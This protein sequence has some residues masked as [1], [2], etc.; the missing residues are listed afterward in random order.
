[1][2]NLNVDVDWKQTNSP[3]VEPIYKFYAKTTLTEKANRIFNGAVFFVVGAQIGLSLAKYIPTLK[4]LSS[5][6]VQIP[7]LTM[8]MNLPPQI[9]LLIPLLLVARKI[10]AIAINIA[11]YPATILPHVNDDHC[12]NNL[13]KDRLETA[14][15]CTENNFRFNAVT[16]SKS[17]VN[18]D[19]FIFGKRTN[20]DNKNWV[21][22]AGGNAWIGEK[23]I[24]ALL[25]QPL[26]ENCN[27]LYV[28]GPGVG[29]SS[30]FATRYSMGAGQESGLQFLEEEMKAEKILLYGTSLG[31]GMQSEAIINHNFKTDVKYMVWSDRTFDKVSNAASA[32]VIG[33]AKFALPIFGTELD[34][35]RGARKLQN[36]NIKHIVTQNNQKSD[37]MGILP[38]E[39]DINS[40]GTDG[41]IPNSASLYVGLREDG[42]NDSARVKFYG[43]RDMKHNGFPAL[44]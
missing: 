44:G 9:R 33:L 27:I 20:I 22:V 24:T 29:R 30:G 13:H 11:V 19:A 28:N 1:M 31:G 32:M 40:L 16:L 18:Y 26:F 14:K 39:G 25:Q 12:H 42:I 2:F 5:T 35:I 21:L 43:S 10:I 37:P 3:N 34:G 6:L 41:V 23:V 38:N 7:A 15:F 8:I 4:V 17:G 36:L